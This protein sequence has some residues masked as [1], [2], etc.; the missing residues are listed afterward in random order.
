MQEFTREFHPASPNEA[1]QAAA[2]GGRYGRQG[3]PTAAAPRLATPLPAPGRHYVPPAS[4]AHPPAQL[5]TLLELT[6]WARDLGMSALGTFARYLEWREFAA[7]EPVF[8]EGDTPRF[9]CI[10]VRGAVEIVKHDSG[11]RDRQLA[12]FTAGK[13]FGEIAL[14]DHEPRSATARA[15]EPTH[16]LVLTDDKLDELALEHPRLGM[17]VAMGIARIVSGRLR[18]TSGRLVDLL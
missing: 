17:N 11:E 5:A 15:V 14:I 6:H 13:T 3:H 8:R 10:L 4:I 9:L 7:G 1:P 18:M 12:R 2:S 16:V